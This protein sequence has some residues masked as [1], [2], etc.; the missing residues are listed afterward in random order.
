MSQRLHVGKT[1]EKV[2]DFVIDSIDGI[3]N[4][5]EDWSFSG[6]WKIS[7]GEADLF[8]IVDPFLSLAFSNGGLSYPD[9]VWFFYFGERSIEH[10]NIKELKD[11]LESK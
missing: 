10:P 3:P 8:R 11:F 2:Y 7:I 9:D 1:S 4:E 5:I 6:L